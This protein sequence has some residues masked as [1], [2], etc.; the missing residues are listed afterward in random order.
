MGDIGEQFHWKSHFRP[1]PVS[2]EHFDS[3]EQAAARLFHLQQVLV[4]CL[5][6]LDKLWRCRQPRRLMSGIHRIVSSTQIVSYET[7]L[8]L[9]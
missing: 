9:F 4:W 6:Q 7:I 8:T 3:V 1:L 2:H 5:E